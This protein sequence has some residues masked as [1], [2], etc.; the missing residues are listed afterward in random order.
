MEPGQGD[1]WAKQKG[2]GNCIPTAPPPHGAQGSTQSPPQLGLIPEDS[3]QAQPQA[4][5]R[6]GCPG[7]Y[8]R[9]IDL[10]EEFEHRANTQWYFPRTLPSNVTICS[11]G[12]SWCRDHSFV[13]NSLLSCQWCCSAAIWT[14]ANLASSSAQVTTSG[15]RG[16][17]LCVRPL[18]AFCK[19]FAL[20]FLHGEIHGNPRLHFSDFLNESTG[21]QLFCLLFSKS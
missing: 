19:L 20:C 8:H 18:R 11:S 7:S 6:N 17:L 21:L 16:E 15:A 3:C 9:A 10:R 12:I 13:F 1:S 5:H 2:R 4:K 14:R